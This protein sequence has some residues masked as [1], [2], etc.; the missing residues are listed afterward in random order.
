MSVTKMALPP[1]RI[2]WLYKRWQ[3]LYYVIRK[4]VF[5]RV[6]FP[7]GIP[8]DLDSDDFFDP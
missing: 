6:E 1:Q 8:M 7:R 3:P 2:V 4:T 5:P